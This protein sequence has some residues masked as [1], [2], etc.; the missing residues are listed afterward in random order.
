MHPSK[1]PNF[2]FNQGHEASWVSH[3]R[4]NIL[5]HSLLPTRR[6]DQV[7]G[8]L[9]AVDGLEAPRKQV[10]TLCFVSRR[11]LRCADTAEAS[12]ERAGSLHGERKLLYGLGEWVVVAQSID[13]PYRPK[14]KKA[15]AQPCDKDWAMVPSR[16]APSAA[17]STC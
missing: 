5:K 8:V 7:K 2:L 15:K 17:K 12:A 6:N 4:L 10:C 1:T 13:L 11:L 3:V 16:V 14:S 9:L